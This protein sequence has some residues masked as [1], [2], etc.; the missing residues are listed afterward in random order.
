[1]TTVTY[2]EKSLLLKFMRYI[3]VCMKPGGDFMLNHNM[4]HV[5][6]YWRFRLQKWEYVHEHYR[7]YPKR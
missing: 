4:V 3:F 7:H 1:M 2:I 5:D 6:A